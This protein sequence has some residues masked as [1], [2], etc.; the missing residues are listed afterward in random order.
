MDEIS[1]TILATLQDNARTTAA[2]LAALTGAAASTCLR[3]LR[4]LEAS[5]AIRGYHADIDPA[6]V[7][8]S[9]QVIAFVTLE[10]EDRATIEAF[11]KE[12]VTI[13]QVISAERLFGDP[14]YLLRVAARDLEDYQRLRDNHLGGLPGLSKITSTMVMRT[15]VEHRPLPL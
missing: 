3:R 6:A 10:R 13:E 11:E 4:A 2:G 15:L 5:G 8:F 9:L 7:G 12:V 14:D 1:R